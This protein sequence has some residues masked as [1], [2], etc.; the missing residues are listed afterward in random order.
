MASL[1]AAAWAAHDVGL[2][3][4]IG[5]TLFGRAALEPALGDISNPEERD[6]VSADAWQRFSW[7]NLAAHGLFAAT[8]LVGRKMLSG[9]EVSHT[10]RRLTAVKDGLILASLVS[11]VSSI[12]LGRRLGQRVERG[13]G[14]ERVRNAEMVHGEQE[15]KRTA[16]MERAVGGLG[17]V[18]LL[19]NIAIASVTA[20]L[21]MEANKSVR[22][23]ARSR[24]LP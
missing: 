2:A 6:R 16:S 17:I 13:L 12:V 18:N 23:A 15:V 22:F 10:A 20:V 3:A 19:A 21:G 11:G 8:W 1:S 5:G 7:I 14:P 24:C 9:R 4:A